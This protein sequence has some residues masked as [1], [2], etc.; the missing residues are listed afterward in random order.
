MG[1]KQD[2]TGKRFG[3]LTAIKPVDISKN[4][5]LV[6]ECKCDCGNHVSVI[7]S[8]LNYGNTKSCGKCRPPVIEKIKKFKD[9]VTFE[10]IGKVKPCR[11]TTGY[12]DIYSIKHNDELI[13][14]VFVHVFGKKVYIGRK[15]KLFDAIKL[16]EEALKLLIK[17]S[18]ENGKKG[19]KKTARTS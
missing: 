2:L 12:V 6:W 8:S 16:Q 9:T 10:D 14:S 1:S 19:T 7:T 5:T 15:K 18:E 17:W 11:S 3:R 13:F 4:G